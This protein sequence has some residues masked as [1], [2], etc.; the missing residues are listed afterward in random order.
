LL[1][2]QDEKNEENPIICIK[3][4]DIH[5]ITIDPSVDEYYVEAVKIE[6][7]KGFTIRLELQH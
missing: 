4:D 1:D 3:L 2:F 5:H 6:L 7:K